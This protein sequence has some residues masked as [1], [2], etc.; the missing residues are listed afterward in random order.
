MTSMSSLN[1]FAIFRS[2]GPAEIIRLTEPGC[3]IE[4]CLANQ[5]LLTLVL[6]RSR[7]ASR[8]LR[9]SL[10]GNAAS[11]DSKDA[12]GMKER[13]VF[14]RGFL[15]IKRSACSSLFFSRTRMKSKGPICPPDSAR[16]TSPR[17]HV[18]VVSKNAGK[19][20]LL[21]VRFRL[22]QS[23]HI[24]R[25]WPKRPGCL[26]GGPGTGCQ[27]AGIR[28]AQLCEDRRVSQILPIPGL[29][30]HELVA[31]SL[32]GY[33]SRHREAMERKYSRTSVRSSGRKSGLES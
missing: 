22:R 1:F 26:P 15:G 33:R 19:P 30:R 28:R 16:M 4:R 23:E 13:V 10:F 27:E 32:R 21:R 31:G 29:Q 11:A 14:L 25:P 18:R 6:L 5:W 3:A 9:S 8:T 12:V 7:Q 20:F 17:R 24:S 2:V